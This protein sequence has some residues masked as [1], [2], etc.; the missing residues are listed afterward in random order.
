[1]E[2]QHVLVAD[3]IDDGIGVQRLRW[4]TVVVR[5]SAK[6]LCGGHILAAGPCID[7]KDGC[8]RKA[9]HHILLHT[10]HNVFVH[11]AKLASVTFVEDQ[12]DVFFLQYLA[13]PFVVVVDVR[14]HQVRQLLN[15]GDDDAHIVILQ[16]F[17][18]D[19]CRRVRVRA[20]RLE[21]VVL[22]HGLVV[23]VFSVYHEEHLL[24]V[25]HL[26]SQLGSLKRCQ[27]LTAASGV[28]D[29]A[30]CADGSLPTVIDS[31]LYALQNL[32]CCGYLI[33][34]HHQQLLI[35]VKHTI[36]G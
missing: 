24:Y 12:H 5:F 14:F 11:V 13:Q 31:R 17:Q 18:Q 30:T 1:M 23:Q 10:F 16:L 2:S 7:G 36:L 25:L 34:T 4:F 26:R 9:K 8:S 22:L 3:G 27:R 6:Q 28:P 21:V 15:R 35:H 32:F 33:G 20:V 19:S 29:V